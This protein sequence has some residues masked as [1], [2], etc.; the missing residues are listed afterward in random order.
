MKFTAW[1]R[2]RRGI[3]FFFFDIC[4]QAGQETDFILVSCTG[5]GVEPN[6]REQVLKAKRVSLTL[7][8]F[9]FFSETQVFL[10]LVGKYVFRSLGSFSHCPIKFVRLVKIH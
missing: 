2:H 8:F 10:K 6:R 5:S 3:N 7:F 4:L 1:Y 9:F